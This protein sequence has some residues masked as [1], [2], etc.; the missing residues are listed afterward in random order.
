[1]DCV[2]RTSNVFFEDLFIKNATYKSV[3]IT[4]KELKVITSF[5]GHIKKVKKM[6]NGCTQRGS[7]TP[8]SRT[9]QA[10][11]FVII[12]IKALEDSNKG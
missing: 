1:M 4:T 6:F 12:F 3:K 10:N 5:H 2:I 7:T 11:R 9:K 8:A